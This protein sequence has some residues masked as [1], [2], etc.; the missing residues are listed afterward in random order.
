MPPYRG[1]VR[2]YAD[3][4]PE[5]SYG[6]QLS[7]SGTIQ[8]SNSGGFNFISFPKINLI[9][10][11]QGSQIKQFLF[12]IKEKFTNS[13]QPLLPAE[14]SA[15]LEGL[16]TGGTAEFSPAFKDAIRQSGMSHIVALS[17]YN[18]SV[19]GIA[20]SFL[21][22]F[23]LTP[24][25][26]FYFSVTA[27]ILF[28]VMTGASASAVRAA[29]MGIILLIARRSGRLYNFRNSI[30]ITAAIMALFNPQI[31]A[32]DIGFELSFGALLGIIYIMPILEKLFR[33]DDV[34]FLSWKANALTT[35]SS[36]IIVLP[37]LIY[38][39]QQFNVFSILSNILILQA[40]PMTMLLGFFLGV[41]GFFSGPLGALVALP[42]SILLKYQIF[43][44]NFFSRT[45][46]FSFEIPAWI[47]FFYYGLL[48]WLFSVLQYKKLA[49][50]QQ[51]SN[52]QS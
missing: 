47:I 21:L 48:L 50:S 10:T 44:I 14:E 6:D 12:A 34:G 46:V 37:L 25:K 49:S 43:V 41:V 33:V 9:K 38:Y 24:Q 18:I 13:F 20:L 40:I 5:F 3:S 17:G 15:L 11:G 1:E 52:K 39:F 29:I 31:L 26:A 2:I 7:F 16:L 4:Y 42:V 8:E 30:V 51:A 23:F 22:G 45:P 36:Q 27:I 32:Y 19:I 35:L 28:V